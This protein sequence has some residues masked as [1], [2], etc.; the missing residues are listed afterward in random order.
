M[1]GWLSEQSSMAHRDI[2]VSGHVQSQAMTLLHLYPR[3][4]PDRRFIT[5]AHVNADEA[6]SIDPK[7][8]SIDV[9]ISGRGAWPVQLIGGRLALRLGVGWR[10]TLFHE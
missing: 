3:A 1:A 7:P 10:Q 4:N 9:L 8:G 5:R 6:Q 2:T